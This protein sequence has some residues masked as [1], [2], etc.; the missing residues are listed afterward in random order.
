MP[1]CHGA[2]RG[3][4][5]RNTG[6]PAGT[7]T[8]LC[9]IVRDCA[10]CA[11]RPV[12][13]PIGLLGA[14]LTDEKMRSSPHYTRQSPRRPSTARGAG[15]RRRLRVLVTSHL[16]TFTSRL[17][18][19][20]AQRPL[21]ASIISWAW[22]LY[23]MKPSRLTMTLFTRFTNSYNVTRHSP[24][25][26]R[27]RGAQ[28]CTQH[29]HTVQATI[30][31]QIGARANPRAPGAAASIEHVSS[32]MIQRA[33]T[34]SPTSRRHAVAAS[35]ISTSHPSTCALPCLRCTQSYACIEHS[36]PECSTALPARYAATAH[37][38]RVAA[39]PLAIQSAAPCAS[40]SRRS[41]PRHES[42]SSIERVLPSASSRARP[43]ERPHPAQTKRVL[44]NVQFER[45]LLK[46]GG[47]GGGS[48]RWPLWHE[49]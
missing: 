36:L 4:A 18:G 26:S 1:E 6:L 47:S 43:P 21:Q 30:Q 19:R 33:L 8:L 9:D 10:L 20:R 34:N 3:I 46:D 25:E 45:I 48:G 15:P 28:Q 31:T 2:R 7:R 49:H 24:R 12:C 32:R 22:A 40:H 11:L 14:P 29:A 27:R 44:L 13:R 42:V 35:S 37:S 41:P 17:A 23:V 5:E 39:R 38:P 16:R